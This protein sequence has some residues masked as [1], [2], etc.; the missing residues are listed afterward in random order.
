MNLRLSTFFLTLA[1]WDRHIEVIRQVLNSIEDFEPYAAFLRLTNSSGNPITTTTLLQFLKDNRFEGSKSG[2]R[3]MIRM[4][5]TRFDDS[6]D[7]EDFLK[8]ILSRD[9]PHNRFSAATRPVYDV[10]TG[11]NLSAE[12]EYH[13]ARFFV[14][15][16]DFLG[17]VIKDSETK[18]I[19]S[20]MNLFE[21][22]V[23][24]TRPEF[25]DF[26]GLAEFLKSSGIKPRDSEIIS[27][28][29]LIDVNDDGVVN[30]LEFIFFLN[31]F[32]DCTP[33]PCIVK[34]MRQLAKEHAADMARQHQCSVDIEIAEKHERDSLG[35][36]LEK[37]QKQH[38]N[39]R[40]KSRERSEPIDDDR[41]S[42]GYVD[43]NRVEE[44]YTN[45]TNRN[46]RMLNEGNKSLR[47]ISR[48]HPNSSSRLSKRVG[49]MNQSIAEAKL[50]RRQYPQEPRDSS[51]STSRTGRTKSEIFCIQ[52]EVEEEGA[53]PGLLFDSQ[54]E[55]A[56]RNRNQRQTNSKFRKTNQNP[57]PSQKR[58]GAPRESGDIH[59]RDI[60]SSSSSYFTNYSQNLTQTT[61]RLLN[62]S[63]DFSISTT[64]CMV[65]TMDDNE[66]ESSD[67]SEMP[68][69]EGFPSSS[70][71]FN[72]IGCFVKKREEG[73]VKE[74]SRQRREIE[75]QDQMRGVSNGKRSSPPPRSYWNANNSQMKSSRKLSKERELRRKKKDQEK[76]SSSQQRLLRESRDRRSHS[77]NRGS[78]RQIEGS[79][80]ETLA[81]CERDV[82]KPQFSGGPSRRE[83]VPPL[84]LK[85]I[86]KDIKKSSLS[87]SKSKYPMNPGYATNITNNT[88]NTK[89]SHRVPLEV[90]LMES[91]RN[92]M[93]KEVESSVEFTDLLNHF[94]GLDSSKE[95]RIGN[96]PAQ[97][98]N[99]LL[100]S[101][102]GERDLSSNRSDLKLRSS[103]KSKATDL[104]ANSSMSPAKKVV[105][106]NES[107]LSPIKSRR[108]MNKIYS[109]G[110]I[111]P[112]NVLSK[113]SR[114][115]RNLEYDLGVQE[116]FKGVR[117]VK[118][119]LLPAR[120]T[121][122]E[123]KPSRLMATVSE[124]AAVSTKTLI[125]N[126]FEGDNMNNFLGMKNT[127]E[128]TDRSG[129]V[130]QTGRSQLAASKVGR[131]R[132]RSQEDAVDVKKTR[133][134]EVKSKMKL[135]SILETNKHEKFVKQRKSKTGKKKKM[136][137]SLLVPISKEPKNRSKEKR[138]CDNGES[139]K[140][141]SDF[142]RLSK[143]GGFSSKKVNKSNRLTLGSSRSRRKLT[144]KENFTISKRIINKTAKKPST[145]K[146]GKK[147][148]MKTK[149]RSTVTKER[150][151]I[152]YNSSVAGSSSKLIKKS[153]R[154][155][156]R[157]DTGK[158]SISGSRH[159]F[160]PVK[161][162]GIVSSTRKIKNKLTSIKKR[163]KK[164]F[165]NENN[166]NT[167]Y[168]P[169]RA[170]M[171]SN[172]K[173]KISVC[174]R[175]S[176]PARNEQ[177]RKSVNSRMEEEAQDYSF[178]T[179]KMQTGHLPE[180]VEVSLQ[181]TPKLTNYIS[182]G[183]GYHTKDS[184]HLRR[185]HERR[186]GHGD[187]QKGAG[188]PS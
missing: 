6:L 184:A 152:K 15:G 39:E 20:E 10:S 163:V 131:S 59:I 93:F 69:P 97:W 117:P 73:Y 114:S 126:T 96:N 17:R 21:R 138:C 118:S 140:Q 172:S 139:V 170:T 7:F 174:P 94:P 90:L 36:S 5:D 67:G 103:L 149:V 46:L 72:N 75:D 9:N 12:L 38:Q 182:I 65:T 86:K 23:G 187:L 66:F 183:S 70:S 57:R 2:L 111:R 130:A 134:I 34:K 49:G 145:V 150:L 175:K 120:S 22:V 3:L 48:I 147:K 14:K 102:R 144:G 25:L 31:L 13:L 40:S 180:D 50:I 87:R 162:R 51:N 185:H 35:A 4:F 27:I 127:I 16:G 54:K 29:R 81:R 156:A 58:S 45:S 92:Q 78:R 80:Q 176:T 142:L 141:F 24:E 47:E 55:N 82:P 79:Y 60:E 178:E 26:G 146:K 84:M 106:F 101:K 119:R 77:H 104:R 74:D 125:F 122:R 105:S 68:R 181:N 76:L 1:E 161:R 167:V 62:H 18:L 19:L 88:N 129:R 109:Q 53:I 85:N 132:N 42:S 64:S 123:S 160:T 33:E 135:R 8:M 137:E 116:V 63:K 91:R 41:R 11:E 28:L 98:P 95:K 153:K 154:I 188:H 71:R 99:P 164:I 148:I 169:S 186:E 155:Q 166:D 115:T 143:E 113:G 133:I 173:R 110:I 107:S 151:S 89:S 83:H 165:S 124:N 177:R 52:E 121:E 179:I 171:K 158:K 159:L 108:G 128:A 56:P 37:I 168:S 100:T 32:N 43:I 61:N 30:K 136:K 112:Q 157:V 44:T